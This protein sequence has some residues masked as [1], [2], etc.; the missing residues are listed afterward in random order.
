MLPDE[1]VSQ[2]IGPP[3]VPEVWKV[4]PDALVAEARH[5]LFADMDD[6][7]RTALGSAGNTISGAVTGRENDQEALVNVEHA[8]AAQRS[9]DE[10][11]GR[12]ALWQGMMDGMRLTR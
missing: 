12:A 4:G 2:N 9:A 1:P 10:V 7:G 6:I 11:H 8:G 3:W 5:A